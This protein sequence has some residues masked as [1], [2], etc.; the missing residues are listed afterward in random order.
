MSNIKAQFLPLKISLLVMFGSLIFFLLGPI[1]WTENDNF[2]AYFVIALLIL[3]FLAFT[4]GYYARTPKNGI[5]IINHQEIEYNELKILNML[6]YTLFLNLI[7]TVLL[8]LIYSNTSSLS[9]LINKMIQGLFAPSEAYYMKDTSSRSGS[10]IVWFSLLYSPWLYITKVLGLYYFKELKLYQ[11]ILYIS[12][13]VVEVMRWLAVGTNKGL[14]DIVVLLLFY[15]ILLRMK[16]LSDDEER[17]NKLKKT[18][19]RIFLVVTISAVAF[20]MFFGTAISARVGG[21][22]HEE[23][24]SSFPYNQLPVGLRFFVEKFDSYLTQGYKNFIL[25]VQ[26]CE[27][28]WTFGIGNSRFLMQ[29]FNS[30]FGIDLTS[31]TYPYQLASFGVDPLASWHTAYGWFASDFTIIGII[32]F[33]FFVGYYTS[34]LAK[35]VIANGDPV[36]MTLL[37]MMILSIVNASCTNY[38]LA[39]SGSFIPFIALHILRWCRKH[40]VVIGK[41]RL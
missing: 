41:F 18:L 2:I 7:F 39:Y 30:L 11:K 23:Y 33:M 32:P 21:A 27:F 13:L 19:R 37:Y 9:G 15:Y 3:Y 6:K 8:A 16:L 29:I 1:P 24:F 38:I 26:N 10:I 17:T 5:I 4:F 40:N 36:S 14:F 20:F 22:Y 12:A 25:I 31:R 28:K 35:E 34:G